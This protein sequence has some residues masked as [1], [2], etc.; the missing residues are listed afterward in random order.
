MGIEA[1]R[2]RGTRS[3]FKCSPQP[4]WWDVAWR[5]YAIIINAMGWS[6]KPRTQAPPTTYSEL[7]AIRKRRETESV[8]TS[9]SGWDHQT[10]RRATMAERIYIVQSAQGTRL[11]KANLRQQA[12]S[13]AANSTF[14]VRVAS[15]DDLVKQLTA[16]TKIEQYRAPE[17]QELIEDSESPG[18]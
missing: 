16:G 1:A 11:I 9:T 13:H 15:Q 8:S 10:T 7:Q 5:E 14:T 4:C 6:D 12:L 17:Q 2:S 3:D 18:N